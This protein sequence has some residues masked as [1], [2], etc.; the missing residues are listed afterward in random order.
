MVVLLNP[1]QK[2]RARRNST[3]TK[4]SGYVSRS[5]P[6]IKN[7]KNSAKDSTPEKL[8]CGTDQKD[9]SQILQMMSIGAVRRILLLFY[10]A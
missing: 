4:Q 10:P 1:F 8:R 9:V 5:G 3:E 6:E 2:M 7:E